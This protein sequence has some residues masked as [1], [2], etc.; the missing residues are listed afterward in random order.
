MENKGFSS[1]VRSYNKDDLSNAKKIANTY[2]KLIQ[3]QEQLFNVV[4]KDGKWIRRRKC[5]S[6]KK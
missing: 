1:K 3:Y 4:Y 5:H 2:I 6:Q